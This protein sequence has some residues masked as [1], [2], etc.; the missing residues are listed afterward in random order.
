MTDETPGMSHIP[1]GWLIAV[2]ALGVVCWVA[3]VAV[4]VFLLGI[5][6]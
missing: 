1:L 6:P 4:L 3:I 5:K 2:F